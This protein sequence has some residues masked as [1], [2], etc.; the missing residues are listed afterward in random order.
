CFPQGWHFKQWTGNDSKALMKVYLP[1]IEGHVPNDIIH[2]L[3]TFLECCYLVRQNV[4]TEDTFNAIQDALDHFHQYHEVFRETGVVLTFSLPHQHSM[5]HYPYLIQQFGTPN[6]LCSSIMESKHISAV[7]DPYRR[8]NHYNTLGPMLLINQHLDK[9]A[10][11]RVNFG[12][13]GMLKGTCLSSVM[14]ALGMLLLRF[15]SCCI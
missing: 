13:W 3:R 14:E 7:K 11:S 4:I 10:A 6:G 2:T 9:L 5:K 12:E 8:T 15:V 1:A